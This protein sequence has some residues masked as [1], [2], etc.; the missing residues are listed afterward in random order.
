MKNSPRII[1]NQQQN[2]ISVSDSVML[3]E[4]EAYDVIKFA[5]N[6]YGYESFGVYTPWLSNE[7]LINLNNNS[8]IPTNVESI[9]KALKDYKREANNL[10]AYSEFMEVFDMLYNR[11]VEYYT[12]LLSFDL[13]ITCKNVKN[14]KEDYTSSRYLEDKARVYK[15]LD[16]FDYKAEFRR[17]VK[18]LLRH[19]THYVSF[20]NNMN[21]N[22]PKYTLQTLPQDRCLLTGYFESGL[23][24]DFDM[25]YFIG[26]PGVDINCYDPIFKKYLSEVWATQGL[27][28]YIPSSPL[29]NRDGTFT[30]FHQTSPMDNFWAFKFDMSNFSSVPFLSP[31]LKNVF[32][33]TEIAKLQKN[34]DIASAFGLLYGE[35]R[36]QES[37]KSG[38][39]PD[40]F[41]LKPETLGKFMRLVSA[42]LK[43]SMTSDS[44]IKSVALPL[45]EAEFKQFED[46]NTGM[47][48]DAA[49]DTVANGASAS[50]LLYATDRMSNEEFIAAV[51]AD[52][53][54]VAKLYSQFNNFLEFY[55]NQKTKQYKFKFT[56]DGC[57]QP[58]WRKRKQDSVMKLADVGL[59]LNS[60][61]Y[62]AAFGYKPTDFDRLLEEG[63]NGGMLDNLSQLLSI[64]NMSN[65]GGRPPSD[66]PLSDSGERSRNQ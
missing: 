15:F 65:P 53:E 43:S 11:T 16:N 3:S 42:G 64:H 51:T 29:S 58:F 33:N 19:E 10:Q 66:E 50:R 8:R 60:S 39:V 28:D 38:E 14:P 32:N 24:F 7:N 6:L 61:A 23:L 35:M 37:A 41:A 22:D 21:K 9:I 52:Y 62:A 4:Q 26:T 47:A 1:P 49:K 27:M 2:N 34:K 20:R 31:F 13:Q 46:K 45:E 5:N 59:V 44:V 55:V 48:I 12:N 54:I 30:L 40:R 18:Q 36:M 25:M 17:V 63:H 56:F 57:T